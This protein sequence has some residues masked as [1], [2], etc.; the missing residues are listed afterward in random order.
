M[1]R[2]APALGL[3]L[4]VFVGSLETQAQ[5]A[6]GHLPRGAP[7]PE[8]PPGAPLEPPQVPGHLRSILGW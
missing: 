8:S 2:I 7:E 6:P 3:L 4:L 1:R 5:Q